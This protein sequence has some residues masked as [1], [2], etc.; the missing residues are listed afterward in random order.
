[1][2]VNL[3]PSKFGYIFSTLT[4]KLFAIAKRRFLTLTIFWWN[5][6]ILTATKD[7]TPKEGES[8]CFSGF[9]QQ[10][11]LMRRLGA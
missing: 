2:L 8:S 4:T 10:C 11:F 9:Y 6:N 1:V 7:K 5:I 3:Y